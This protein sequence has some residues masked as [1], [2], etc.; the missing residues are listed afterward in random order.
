MQEYSGA[1]PA[2]VPATR[3]PTLRMRRSSSL[4]SKMQRLCPLGPDYL[5]ST[6]HRDDNSFQY[7]LPDHVSLEQLS[8]SERYWH[9][10]RDFVVV[11]I[12]GQW[13]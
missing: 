8:Q 9:C 7:A 4:L 6:P 11:D 13:R 5:I 12:G 2:H 10:H 3:N 1:P